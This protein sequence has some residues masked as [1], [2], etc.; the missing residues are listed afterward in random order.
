MTPRST[1]STWP[2]RTPGTAPTRG[3][4]SRRASTCCARSRSRSISGRRPGW[5]RRPAPTTASSWRR[6]GAASCPPTASSI[7][8]S[9]PGAS[10]RS[11]SSRPT[12]AS[13]RRSTPP[14]GSSTPRSAAGPRSI[15][16]CTPCSSRTWSSGRPIRCGRSGHRGRTGVDEQV[17]AVMHH[18]GGAM[19]VV[20]AA[21]SHVD[22]L[23][24]HDHRHRG[25]DPASRRS[26]TAR[27]R[28]PC[29]TAPGPSVIETP[30]EGQGLRY[31]VP[32]VHRCIAE[33]LLESP[34]MSHAESCAIAGTLDAILDQVA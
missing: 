12:S 7:G 16:A 28:S 9:P 31:Q 20:K 26:C 22:G 1:W 19:A 14:T 10:A 15:S 11:V 13:P 30:I 6:S 2:P 32:E 25:D 27:S 23:H 33:G 17:A 21:V 24:R 4:T 34:M 3:S 29:R 18:A 8:C 5:W